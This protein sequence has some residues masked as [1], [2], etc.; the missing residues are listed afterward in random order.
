MSTVINCV[1]YDGGVRHAEVDLAEAR[2]PD[3]DGAFIWVGLQEPNKELLR[4]V[5][6]RFNLHDLAVEDALV[7]H[8]RPKLEIYGDSIFVALR[9]AQLIDKKIQFGETHIFAG[10]AYVVTV[11]HGSTTG[12]RE[13][14]ARAEVRRCARRR[15]GRFDGRRPPPPAR[16]P[17]PPCRAGPG[18]SCRR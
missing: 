13:V 17:R 14:R 7:A 3:K 6:Q 10:P 12:Y 8:Q 16:R 5:Q 11:R 15:S 2:C 1:S 4:T 18:S 9:T